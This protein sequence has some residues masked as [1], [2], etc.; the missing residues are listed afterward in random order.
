VVYI[1]QKRV[2]FVNAKRRQGVLP[3][4]ASIQDEE[5]MEKE[6]SVTAAQVQSTFTTK[7]IKEPKDVCKE[8]RCKN[9]RCIPSKSGKDYACKCTGGFG[10]RFCDLG[11]LKSRI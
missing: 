1:N 6:V 2:D 11:L 4:C 9:G 10:G 3:G 5:P 8:S 7:I